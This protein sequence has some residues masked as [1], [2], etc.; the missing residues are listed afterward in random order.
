MAKAI[1]HLGKIY[2]STKAMCDAYGISPR[3]YYDRRKKGHT[4][5]EAL[6]V[7]RVTDH[8]GNIYSS[9]RAMCREYGIKADT[10]WSRRKKGYSLEE[11]LTKTKNKANC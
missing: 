5:G 10:Y 1:D 3:T 6:T 9:E 7:K 8:L 2:P 11:A 4:K